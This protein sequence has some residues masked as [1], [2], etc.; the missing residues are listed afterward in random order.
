MFWE[1]KQQGGM[2]DAPFPGELQDIFSAYRESLP[3]PEP[4]ANFTP[5]LWSRIEANKKATYRFGRVAKGF[6]AAGATACL[7]IAGLFI[8]PDRNAT[9]SSSTY[10][11]VL[12]SDHPEDALVVELVHGD[13][14]L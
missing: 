5:M 7:L 13:N 10:V 12:A 2:T 11:D 1:K 6:V 3:D 14:S 9:L 8:V 4:S